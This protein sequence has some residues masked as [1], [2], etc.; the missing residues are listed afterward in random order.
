MSQKDEFSGFLFR[1]II[2]IPQDVKVIFEMLD[3]TNFSDRTQLRAAGSLLYL[4]A[5]GDLIPDT[6][7]LLGHADDSL[8]LRITMARILRQE[9]DRAAHYRA[10]YPEVFDTL[11]AD[12]ATAAG[13]LGEAYPWLE[14]HLDRLETIE[15]KGK[16]PQMILDDVEVGSWLYDEINEAM[17]DLE[18]DEDELG[19]ELRKVDRILTVLQEKMGFP[20]R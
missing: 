13:Y 15:F 8:V 9:P 20:R 19:R 7:G 4:L 1:S 2:E 12:L 18:I 16:K 6:F 3:D 14:Q 17:L 11:D 5:P 10:R